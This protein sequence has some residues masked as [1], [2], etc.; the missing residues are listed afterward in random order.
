MSK[1]F[2][3]AGFY[4]FGFLAAKWHAMRLGRMSNRTILK[5]VLPLQASTQLKWHA[6]KTI[7]QLASAP[8]VSSCLLHFPHESLIKTYIPGTYKSFIYLRM[9]LTAAL[10]IQTARNFLGQGT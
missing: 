5:E 2:L 9:T 8:D 1:I 7:Q 4:H 6:I 3:Q 10:D